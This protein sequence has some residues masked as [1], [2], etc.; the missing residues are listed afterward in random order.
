MLPPRS[1]VT[2]LLQLCNFYI[3][4]NEQSITKQW[5]VCKGMTLLVGPNITGPI[6]EDSA[7][8]YNSLQY[9]AAADNTV[10]TL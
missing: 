6:L 1:L 2:R 4:S 9:T 5:H 10:I 8:H 7:Y 3:A